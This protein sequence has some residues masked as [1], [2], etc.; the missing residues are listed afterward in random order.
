MAESAEV[1][2]AP[3][4][5]GAPEDRLSAM[6]PTP[7]LSQGSKWDFREGLPSDLR[8]KLA[9]PDVRSEE[10]RVLAVGEDAAGAIDV[11]GVS[12]VGFFSPQ[13]AMTI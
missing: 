11:V 4:R 12:K 7:P 1:S 5:L 2:G 3:L 9:R 6:E 8:G 13:I 10:A